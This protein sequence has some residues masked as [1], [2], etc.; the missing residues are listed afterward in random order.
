MAESLCPVVCHPQKTDWHLPTSSRFSTFAEMGINVLGSYLKKTSEILNLVWSW[1][2]EL[3]STLGP[4][5]WVHTGLYTA[6]LLGDRL[7]FNDD[8]NQKKI[9]ISQKPDMVCLMIPNNW[10]Y[11]ILYGQLSQTIYHSINQLINSSSL[12]PEGIWFALE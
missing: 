6:S 8:F 11:S 7:Q 3:I 1:I 2:V 5:L 4:H 12:S 10:P 9:L